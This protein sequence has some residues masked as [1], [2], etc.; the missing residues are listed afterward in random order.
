MKTPT[1]QL[2]DRTAEGYFRWWAPVLRPMA[3][4]LAGRIDRLAPHLAGGADGALLDVG[5]GT[6]NFV[7]E[8][9]RRWPR[10]RLTGLDAADGMLRVLD[11]ERARLDQA[12]ASRISC[13]SG[14]AASLPFPDASFDIVTSVFVL[15]Q[16][17]D[18]ITVLAEMA[19]VLRPGG[20][21]GIVGW[22]D[23][24][25]TYAPEVELELA[26]AEARV[27]RPTPAIET[28]GHYHSMQT[29]ARELRRVGLRQV[30]PR[31]TCLDHPWT[32]ADFITYRRTTRDADLFERLDA[33]ASRRTIEALERRLSKLT[34]DQLVYRESVVT[35][36]ARK[37]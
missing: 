24:D 12:A 18:R 19:R 25:F 17:R 33:D 2:L 36:T 1:V 31:Q 13:V 6:G 30:S 20:I 16:V 37:P 28:A 3:P 32:A 15:Q 11:R 14:D 21:M 34:R 22:L 8:A 35:I 9:A 4:V 26:L 27:N 23:T 7:F 10:V 5:C 29:A